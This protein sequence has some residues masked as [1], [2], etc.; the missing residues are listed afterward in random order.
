MFL[1]LLL[2]TAIA[3]VMYA[4]GEKTAAAA[5]LFGSRLSGERGE[6]AVQLAGQAIRSVALGV[7][8]TALAQSVIGGIGLWVAGLPFAGLLTALMFVLCL[9]QLGPALV[10]VPAVIWTTTQAT[11]LGRPCC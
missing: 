9:V 6:R 5:F 1:Q 8:V 10:L 2:T 7:V 11:L 3:A 4:G